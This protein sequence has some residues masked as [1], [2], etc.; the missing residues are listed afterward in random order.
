MAFTQAHANT[1]ETEA[2]DLAT[3]Q[4]ALATAMADYQ[5][6]LDTIRQN[7]AGPASVQG[8]GGQ[9]YIVYQDSGGEIKVVEATRVT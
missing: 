1:Y 6:A 5:S 9:E 8:S 4:A 2:G 7:Y 3:A